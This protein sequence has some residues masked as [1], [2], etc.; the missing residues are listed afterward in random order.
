MIFA[1]PERTMDIRKPAGVHQ[2]R[3][4]FHTSQTHQV[5]KQRFHQSMAPH[6]D[7]ASASEDMI[8]CSVAPSI[9]TSEESETPLLRAY[10]APNAPMEQSGVLQLSHK[11]LSLAWARRGATK[12]LVSLARLGT[13][14]MDSHRLQLMAM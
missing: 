12:S 8:S 7:N 6:E 4:S 10:C 13:S 5:A 3:V 2:S 14:E 11:V 9:V 1:L